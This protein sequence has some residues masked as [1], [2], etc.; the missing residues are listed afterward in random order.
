MLNRG[1]VCPRYG[2]GNQRVAL[3]TLEDASMSPPPEEGNLTVLDASSSLSLQGAYPSTYMGNVDIIALERRLNG[4]VGPLDAYPF[5]QASR[6]RGTLAVDY[7]GEPKSTPPAFIW[8]DSTDLDW[9]PSLSITVSII[10]LNST[11]ALSLPNLS[12]FVELDGV[13]STSLPPRMGRTLA[14]YRFT[15][16]AFGVFDPREWLYSEIVPEV[17][18]VVATQSYAYK[19]WEPSH[20]EKMVDFDLDLEITDDDQ[21]T[22]LIYSQYRAPGFTGDIGDVYNMVARG[23]FRV[24]FSGT[25][26]GYPNY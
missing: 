5:F 1:F 16:P 13:F 2:S 10:V 20:G 17:G 18:T 26:F 6:L 22:F 12:E 24:N 25:L 4:A 7:I 19:Y 9:F 8:K 3:A 21:P 15:T 14:T 11:E 23:F